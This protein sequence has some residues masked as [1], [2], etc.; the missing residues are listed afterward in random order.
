A[1]A[2]YFY[3]HAPMLLGVVTL[4][5]GVKVTIGHAAQPHPAR[6]ALALGVGIAL[7]LAGDAAF[8]EVMGMGRPWARYGTAVF[9]VATAAVGAALAVE[10]QLAVLTAGLVGML[11]AEHQLASGPPATGPSTSGGR[12]G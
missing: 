6:Q 9:A 7:F 11:L 10:A 2:G 4:A 12:R 8:R 5:A 1:L 3:A